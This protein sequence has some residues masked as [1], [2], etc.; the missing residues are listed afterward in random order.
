MNTIFTIGILGFLEIILGNNTSNDEAHNPKIPEFV[1]LAHVFIIPISLITLYQFTTLESGW[2]SIVGAVLST[3]ISSGTCGI[4]IAHELIHRRDER[5]QFYGQYLLMLAGNL[6]FYIHHLRIHH[7]MVGT[8]S[9]P[10]SARK[11]E[12]VYAFFFRSVAGQ[13]K[14][15]IEIEKKRGN[16]GIQSYPIGQFVNH[17]IIISAA[18][19]LSQNYIVP[20][21]Y[22]THAV[23]ASFLLEYVNYIEHYGLRRLPSDRPGPEISWQSDRTISRF[24]L[25]DLS[26]HSDHHE[27]P[28]KPFYTLN[29]LPESPTLPG[30]YFAMFIPALI[31]FWWFKVVN[32]RIPKSMSIDGTTAEE[33]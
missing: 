32:P 33:I 5:S 10:A 22:V 29:T 18:T 3:A 25:F 16:T 24:M 14:Q 9:D 2:V 19:M 1:L 30:G 23:L 21:L 12:T 4:V 8:D 20:I 15:V 26:R 7:P 6:Y 28:A 17:L 13:L 31:P 27:R 11:N